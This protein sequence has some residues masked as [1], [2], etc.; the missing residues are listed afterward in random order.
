TAFTR[1]GTLSFV[2]TSCGGM[3]KVIVRRSTRTMRSTIGIRKNSPG[4]LGSWTRRPSRKTMPR[5]YSRRTLTAAIAY[6]STQNTPITKTI[7]A[8]V[9]SP[10]RR[11]RGRRLRSWVASVRAYGSH[12]DPMYLEGEAVDAIDL[13]LL[14]GDEPVVRARAPELAVDEDEPVVTH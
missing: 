5:S 1:T 13:D 6:S 2:I 11:R 3:F 14:A 4:P 9:N 12:F 7:S 8:A 10:L